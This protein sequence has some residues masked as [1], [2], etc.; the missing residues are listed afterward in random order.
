MRKKDFLLH[1][2]IKQYVKCQEPI[3]SESLKSCLKGSVEGRI[4]SATIR[5]Y[6]KILGQ[7]GVLIQTHISSGRVPTRLALRNYWREVLQPESLEPSIDSARLHAVCEEFG[8]TCALRP[9]GSQKLLRVLE[10][11]TNDDGALVLVFERDCVAI[12]FVA[13]MARF[14][15]ELVGVQ[16]HD[17][18]KI[19]RDVCAQSLSQALKALQSVEKT[20]FFGLGALGGVFENAPERALEF[21]Q[22]EMFGQE[23]A[24]HFPESS[25]YLILSH[26]AILHGERVQMLTLG[27]LNQDYEGFY[28]ALAS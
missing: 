20:K 13:N 11:D 12:P 21:V 4:S 18:Q 5:N 17:L 15:H 6:F 19:A 24:L 25:D 23:C 27:R 1:Q 26:R 2:M 16:I 3:G 8:L 9:S 22:G 14:C 7:E 28:E 10:V